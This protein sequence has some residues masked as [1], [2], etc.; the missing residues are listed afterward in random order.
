ML[1]FSVWCLGRKG[2]ELDCVLTLR[3]FLLFLF[4]YKGVPAYF[5]L[6]STLRTALVLSLVCTMKK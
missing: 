1:L 4:C 2:L 3:F 5:L 6:S